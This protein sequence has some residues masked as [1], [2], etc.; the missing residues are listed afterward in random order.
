MGCS[1]AAGNV[2]DLLALGTKAEPFAVTQSIDTTTERKY[3]YLVYFIKTAPPL[4]N[5]RHTHPCHHKR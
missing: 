2:N 4:N 1:E 5:A 3:I